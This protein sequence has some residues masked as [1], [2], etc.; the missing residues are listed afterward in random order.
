MLVAQALIE[1]R[2]RSFSVKA[3]I[4]GALDVDDPDTPVP[5]LQGDARIRTRFAVLSKAERKDEAP[6]ASSAA[7]TLQ[8]FKQ[9]GSLQGDG[10]VVDHG[11]KQSDILFVER[12]LVVAVGAQGS[13]RTPRF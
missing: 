8:S 11:C 3:P 2:R 9:V 13:H 5:R 12:T 7:R 4:R 1:R 6:G 10:S